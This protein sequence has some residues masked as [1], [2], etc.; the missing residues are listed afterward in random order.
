MIS[1]YSSTNGN[2]L[3][4]G[5]EEVSLPTA[6]PPRW[7]SEV[8][9][10]RGDDRDELR[11]RVRELGDFLA[12]TPAVDLKDLAFT[13]NTPLAPGGSRLAVVVESATDLQSRLG[14]AAERLADPRCRQIKDSRG[15]YYFERW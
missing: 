15:S 13:L 6:A 9:V 2:R 11:E 8:V 12:R 10:L 14:R 5:R 1:T 3:N 4:G 7:D